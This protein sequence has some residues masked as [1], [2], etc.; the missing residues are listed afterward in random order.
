M[1][2]RRNDIILAVIVMVIALG[3]I[4]YMQVNKQSGGEV[5]ITVG[6]EVYRKLPLGKDD[7]LEIKDADGDDNV[8]VIK[9]GKVTMESANCPDQVC[10]KHGPIQYKGETI[11][12]LPHKLVVEITDGEA[13]KVD[14][15]AQ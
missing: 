2:L 4:L 6:G 14:V 11:V 10:V 1:K 12:C 8:V 7:R 9:D 5:T 15:I 13:S 3:A